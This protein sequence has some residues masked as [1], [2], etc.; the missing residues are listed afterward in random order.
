MTTAPLIDR[1][2]K[3]AQRAISR[4]LRKEFAGKRGK[5]VTRKDRG[6]PGSEYLLI[7]VPVKDDGS[8][9]AG[10]FAPDDPMHYVEV[11]LVF[12]TGNRLNGSDHPYYAERGCS[13]GWE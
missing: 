12:T 13:G 1:I 7:S 10:V 11:S 8:E 5:T 2:E 6:Y 9:R 4:A 3:R